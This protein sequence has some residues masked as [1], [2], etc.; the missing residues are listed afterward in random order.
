MSIML[1]KI[2]MSHF[3]SNTIGMQIKTPTYVM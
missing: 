3:A 2:G 1:S